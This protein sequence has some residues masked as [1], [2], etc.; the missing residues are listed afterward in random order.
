MQ[1]NVNKQFVE[2]ITHIHIEAGRQLCSRNWHAQHKCWWL[3]SSKHSEQYSV[4]EQLFRS[5]IRF[6]GYVH[7]GSE[8]WY[9]TGHYYQQ[10]SNTQRTTWCPTFKFPAASLLL[11]RPSKWLSLVAV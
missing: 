11:W 8:Q 5:N 6:R 9:N 1:S 4:L 3:S 2:K 7:I 10:T